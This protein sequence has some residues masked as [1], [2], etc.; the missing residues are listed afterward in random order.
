MRLRIRE[1]GKGE[2]LMCR[3]LIAGENPWNGVMKEI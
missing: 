1:N 2:D 3:D